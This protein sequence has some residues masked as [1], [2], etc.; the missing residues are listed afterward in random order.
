MQ[1]LVCLYCTRKRDIFHSSFKVSCGPDS[2]FLSAFWSF[3]IFLQT[4]PSLLSI[5]SLS[6]SWATLPF[7]TFPF[8][9]FPSTVCLFHLITFYTQPLS[10]CSPSMPFRSNLPSISMASSFTYICKPNTCTSPSGRS[11]GGQ[12]KDLDEL[13]AKF[14]CAA[15]G[16][17]L[18]GVAMVSGGKL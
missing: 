7:L 11:I 17:M 5:M 16:S 3:C 9:L 8:S 14:S 13:W 2:F 6:F 12:W 4:L 15:P 10:S 18:G 1:L